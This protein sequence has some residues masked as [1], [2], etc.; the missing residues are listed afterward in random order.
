MR[1][2]M[3]LRIVVFMLSANAHANT[4]GS[5]N[6]I[7]NVDVGSRVNGMIKVMAIATLV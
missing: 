5:G 6:G 2:L 3:V 4:S 1:I 7:V